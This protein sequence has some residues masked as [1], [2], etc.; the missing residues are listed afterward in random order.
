MPLAHQTT[1]E[2]VMGA[3]EAILIN[4]GPTPLALVAEVLE[5][6]PANATAA[7]E[8]AAELGLVSLTGADYITSSPLTNQPL[9]R[10]AYCCFAHNTN[11]Y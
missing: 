2:H 4:G 9:Y 8:M 5:T 11:I 6:T 7:L 3:V 10:V 1:A